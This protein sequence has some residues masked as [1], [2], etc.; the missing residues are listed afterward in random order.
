MRY[1]DVR[2][3]DVAPVVA[4]QHQIISGTGGRPGIRDIALVESALAAPTQGLVDELFH[5]SLAKMASAY[6]YHL[7]RD[8][9][10]VDGNKRIALTVATAFLIVNGYNCQLQLA[11]EG[12]MVRV[13]SERDFDRRELVRW[14]VEMMG[15]DEPVTF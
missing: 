15:G 9:G 12:Q 1:D 7:A 2:F 5:P 10:F 13:A 14:F 4:I 6:C 8:H 3:L 11:W